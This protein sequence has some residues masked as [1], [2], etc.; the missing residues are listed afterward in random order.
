MVVREFVLDY[1]THDRAHVIWKYD[2]DQPMP[3][4]FSVGPLS[5]AK[6]VLPFLLYKSVQLQKCGTTVQYKSLQLQYIAKVYNNK[7]STNLVVSRVKY[8]RNANLIHFPARL[9]RRKALSAL[10]L[11]TDHGDHSQYAWSSIYA[12]RFVSVR[13][14]T[15]R[16]TDW[17]TGSD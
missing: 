2:N 8:W 17:L 9:L 16:L 12:A 7:S 3:V 4:N 13:L 5:Y 6:S 14:L 10:E 1:V 11:N 15:D